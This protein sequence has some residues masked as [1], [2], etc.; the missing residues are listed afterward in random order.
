MLTIFTC[1]KSFADPHTALIQRNA[2]TSWTKLRPRPEILIFGDEKGIREIYEELGLKNIPNVACNSFGTPLL[3]DMFYKA[4]RLAANDLL[5]YVNSDII[6]M[7]DFVKATERFVGYRHPFLLSGGR[8][9]LDVL[10]RIDFNQTAWEANLRALVKT[11][12]WFSFL[13]ND[14][15]LFS[16]GFYSEIPP[17]AIGRYWFDSWLFWKARSMAARIIDASDVITVV[18]QKH[19][20]VASLTEGPTTGNHEEIRINAQLAGLSQGCLLLEATHLLT[21]SGIKRVWGRKCLYQLYNFFVYQLKGLRHRLG[22]RGM[23]LLRNRC[24]PSFLR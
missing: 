11:K 9:G 8:W 2:L 5:C 7:S 22:L 21:N 3:N 1:P 13:F 19:D 14:Y 12:G 23:K 4:Q 6:L 15:F 10:E 17:L 16:R 20:N 18:H 24:L